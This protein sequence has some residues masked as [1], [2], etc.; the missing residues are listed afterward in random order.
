M[1][2]ETVEHKKQT[3][4]NYFKLIFSVLKLGIKPIIATILLGFIA[5][6]LMS[7]FGGLLVSLFNFW[8]SLFNGALGN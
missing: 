1:L 3:A 4:L 2:K 5:I 6:L 7:F 8:L